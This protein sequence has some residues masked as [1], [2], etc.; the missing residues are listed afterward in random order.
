MDRLI[1]V[2]AKA[3]WREGSPLGLVSAG[4]DEE[5]KGGDARILDA[6]EL[7]AAPNSSNPS[8]SKR[9]KTRPA[10]SAVQEESDI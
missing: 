7:L 3:A 1:I 6:A 2:G 10:N 8:N 9:S 5:V 4:F